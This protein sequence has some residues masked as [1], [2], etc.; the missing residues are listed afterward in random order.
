MDCYRWCRV[1]NA[2]GNAFVVLR[3]H[4]ARGRLWEGLIAILVMSGLNWLEMFVCTIASSFS[5]REIH[6]LKADGELKFK[7]PPSWQNKLEAVRLSTSCFVQHFLCNDDKEAQRATKWRWT[8][9]PQQMMSKIQPPESSLNQYTTSSSTLSL[10]SM[11]RQKTSE[12][13]STPGSP[14]MCPS[15]QG[16]HSCAL[17]WLMSI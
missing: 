7:F 9:L 6:T 10:L 17:S 15:S 4:T 3:R 1:R 16:D 14:R 8:H 13:G 11:P 5:H 2:V 12:N